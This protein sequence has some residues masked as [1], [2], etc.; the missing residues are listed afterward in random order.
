MKTQVLLAKSIWLIH[1]RRVEHSGRNLARAV[2]ALLKQWYNFEEPKA[3]DV[4]DPKGVEFKGGEFTTPDNRKIGVIVTVYNDGEV[5]QTATSTDD[6]D[7][8]MEH[9]MKLLASEGLIEYS[10]D[11]VW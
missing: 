2:S 10:P 5:V 3:F 9:T 11:M 7:A 1:M 8:F 4:D 6:G